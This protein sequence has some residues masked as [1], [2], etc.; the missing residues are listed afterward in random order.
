[1]K[2]SN[3]KQINVEKT[4]N[5][6]QNHYK[7]YSSTKNDKKTAKHLKILQKTGTRKFDKMMKK[8][9]LL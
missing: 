2:L 1:M 7:K 8:Y 4:K 5:K 9:R 3:K 6:V